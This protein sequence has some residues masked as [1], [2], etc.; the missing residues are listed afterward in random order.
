[1]SQRD[2]LKVPS[3][4][5]SSFRAKFTSHLPSPLGPNLQPQ[6]DFCVEEE[7]SN[8]SKLY[9][10]DESGILKKDNIKV[11]VEKALHHA[12]AAPGKTTLHQ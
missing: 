11:N 10:N 9:K 3:S 8:A 2:D 12:H 5:N 1:M 4:Q 6:I 7:E